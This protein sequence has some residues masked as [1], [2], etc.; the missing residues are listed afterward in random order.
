MCKDLNALQV[1]AML[2]F[3]R[4]CKNIAFQMPA[5]DNDNNE[6]KWD[7]NSTDNESFMEMNE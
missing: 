2:M 3:L 6:V 5:R 7:I 1:H 4:F